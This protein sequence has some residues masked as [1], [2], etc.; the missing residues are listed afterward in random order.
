MAMSDGKTLSGGIYRAVELLFPSS[1]HVP[2]STFFVPRSTFHHRSVLYCDVVG[3][4]F[5]AGVDFDGV[6]AAGDVFHIDEV[7][8]VAH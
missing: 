5:A 4:H 1:F 8:A 3:C 6:V 7:A 2:L